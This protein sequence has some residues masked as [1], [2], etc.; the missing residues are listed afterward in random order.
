LSSSSVIFVG[1][2]EKKKGEK[3]RTPSQDHRC[4][5]RFFFLNTA[6]KKAERQ[7]YITKFLHP[8]YFFVPTSFSYTWLFVHGV[9][10]SSSGAAAAAR[11]STLWLHWS[12][13]VRH[14][15]K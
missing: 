8:L 2:E 9:C 3:K 6:D 11:S 13:L 14:S 7:K 1:L 5:P 15:V 12:G 10:A 4:R